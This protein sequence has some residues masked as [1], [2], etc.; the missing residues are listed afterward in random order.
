MLKQWRFLV[1]HTRVPGEDLLSFVF[2]SIIDF[3]EGVPRHDLFEISLYPALT[4][5]K[6]T[7]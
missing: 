7:V 1:R 5:L 4:T 6:Y 3:A 2:L